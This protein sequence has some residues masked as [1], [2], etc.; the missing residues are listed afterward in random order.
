MGALLVA[1][2]PPVLHLVVLS[3]AVWRV[4]RFLIEDFLF[5]SVRD[6]LWSKF[7]P[8]SSKFGYLFTCYWCLSVWVA[9]LFIICYTIVPVHTVWVSLVL[10]ISAIVGL[11]AAFEQRL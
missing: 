7:P 11:L 5:A 1:D 2:F 6:R 4:S 3:L 10:A 8:E 9:S